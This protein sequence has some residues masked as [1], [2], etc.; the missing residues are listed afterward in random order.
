MEQVSLIQ[1]LSEIGIIERKRIQCVK[2]GDTRLSKAKQRITA[3]E[4]RMIQMQKEH[5]AEC[6]QEAAKL[7]RQVAQVHARTHKTVSELQAAADA[8]IKE[9]KIVEQQTFEMLAEIETVKAGTAETRAKL[10]Q[11]VAIVDQS[12]EE[13]LR[14][15]NADTLSLKENAE[16]EVRGIL[17]DIA[18]ESKRVWSLEDHDSF[19]R[20]LHGAKT[21]I[22]PDPVRPQKLLPFGGHHMPF[23]GFGTYGLK[24]P[25]KPPRGFME[26]TARRKSMIG[27]ARSL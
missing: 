27:A 5:D 17:G 24:P 21:L 13:V 19:A 26:E 15:A 2:A 9:R 18:A 23:D 14:N 1:D 7:S 10:E 25:Q 4:A 22:A 12:M 16:N 20:D 11:E 8:V 3:A 6:A